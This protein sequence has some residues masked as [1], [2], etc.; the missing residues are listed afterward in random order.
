MN[1]ANRITDEGLLSRISSAAGHLAPEGSDLSTVPQAKWKRNLEGSPDRV[2][3]PKIISELDRLNSLNPTALQVATHGARSGAGL[4]EAIGDVIVNAVTGA[5]SDDYSDEDIRKDTIS[6]RGPQSSDDLGYQSYKDISNLPDQQERLGHTVGSFATAIADPTSLLPIGTTFAKAVGI[7]AGLGGTNVA[8]QEIAQDGEANI[9]DVGHGMMYGA[10]IGGGLYGLGAGYA[11]YLAYK[12]SVNLPVTGKELQRLADDPYRQAVPYPKDTAMEGEFIPRDQPQLT[13]QPREG[14]TID[15][16]NQQP[17][18]TGPESVEGTNI[19]RPLLETQATLPKS[20]DIIEGQ[21]KVLKEQADTLRGDITK[22]IASGDYDAAA[23]LINTTLR[24][25][26]DHGVPKNIR[27]VKTEEDLWRTPGQEEVNTLT[28]L[29]GI[30]TKDNI[31]V[32]PWSSAKDIGDSKGL[33]SD[34]SKVDAT[35]DLIIN[36]E[37]SIKNVTTLSKSRGKE[38]GNID[39]SLL[40]AMGRSGIGAGVGYV[41]TGDEYG[42]LMGAA[43]GLGLP[44]GRG[45]YTRMIGKGAKLEAKAP[46][47]IAKAEEDYSFAA[48]QGWAIRSPSFIL[49]A[50]FGGL[51]RLF[52]DLMER[53]QTKFEGTAG[54]KLWEIN[55]PARE[56][57]AAKVDKGIVEKAETDAMNF[58]RGTVKE[59]ELT[60]LGKSIAKNMSHYFADVLK[61]S[62][63]AG[64]IS[65]KEYTRLASIAAKKQYFPR[66]YDMAFLST[67]AGR[68]KWVEVMTSHKWKPD[69]LEKTLKNI[70]GDNEETAK[71]IREYT[72]KT[73]GKTSQIYISPGLARKMLDNFRKNHKVSRSG[74]LEHSRKIHV[75]EESVLDPFVIKDPRAAMAMYVADAE[76]RIAYASTFGA[77]DEKAISGIKYIEDKYGNRAARFAGELYWQRVGDSRS[78]M[79]SKAGELSLAEREILGRVSAF[80]TLKLTMAPLANMTQ[81]SVNGMIATAHLAG[82]FKTNLRIMGSML[83]DL[84]NNRAKFQETAERSGAVLETSLMQIIGEFSSVEHRIFGR[85]FT[86]KL[87]F[88]EFF[89]HPTTFLR[90]T[91]FVGAERMQRVIGSNWGRSYAELLIEDLNKARVAGKSTARIEA[92]MRE[93][94]LDPTKAVW[95]EKEVLDAALRWSDHVNFRNTPGAMPLGWAHP[96][97]LWFRKF[98]TYAFNQTNFIM[99]HVVKPVWKAETLGGKVSGGLTLAMAATIIGVPLNTLR[100]VLMG[101]DKEL[102]LTKRLV[103]GLSTIGGFGMWYDITRSRNPATSFLGP[104]ASDINTGIEAGKR[105]LDKHSVSRLLSDIVFGTTTIPGEKKF[106]EVFLPGDNGGDHRKKSNQMIPMNF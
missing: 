102:T 6:R 46:E 93:L 13:Q 50:K 60:T 84:K 47:A 71:L 29:Y 35:D 77:N 104:V 63:Q 27:G 70:L 54:D 32:D 43:I 24:L 19:G 76:K 4:I 1:E 10:A 2:E 66:Q 97:A 34:T 73:T 39:P 81:A 26:V 52:D 75:E 18:L 21:Y 41:A 42:A 87:K 40:A 31:I 80:Q 82:G 91:G 100:S 101:D 12:R 95:S 20:G 16:T 86:G 74:H 106:K 68:D 28:K 72:S 55:R 22:H 36:D 3:D 85:E 83:K 59:T 62:M 65:G 8:M 58:L 14:T 61:R 96:H 11:K 44:Y 9:S 37:R 5:V 15:A 88:L 67:K 99:D 57:R 92:Q 56:A 89:N 25:G 94:K 79:I 23:S 33:S 38:L 105:Y 7:G 51:G 30:P 53:A 17:L 49:R 98:K 90:M 69:T 103:G 64:I 78:A 48:W 45:L